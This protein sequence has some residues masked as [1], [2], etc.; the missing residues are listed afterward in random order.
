MKNWKK[1][2]EGNLV[3][4]IFVPSLVYGYESSNSIES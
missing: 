1:V 2:F 3:N 4:F